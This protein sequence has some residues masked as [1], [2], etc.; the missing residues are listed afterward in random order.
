MANVGR[1][2]RRGVEVVAF[3]VVLRE[4][5]LVVCTCL[6]TSDEKVK[7][8]L[9]YGNRV[10]TFDVSGHLPDTDTRTSS[11]RIGTALSASETLSA[12]LDRLAME[13]YINGRN[14]VQVVP[15][16]PLPRC[17]ASCKTGPTLFS[18]RF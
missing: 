16:N 15:S 14:H 10:I 9:E 13:A 8:P 7:P 18:P 4:I 3:V 17:T 2:G 11:Q 1:E 5:K 12:H 6:V